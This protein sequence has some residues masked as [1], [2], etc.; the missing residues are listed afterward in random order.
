MLIT[1][2][3][4][5]LNKSMAY[6]SV[7]EGWKRKKKR[8]QTGLKKASDYPRGED[9]LGHLET[10]STRL[11]RA[12]RQLGGLSGLLGEADTLT[13][14]ENEAL[15]NI[16]NLNDQ[17]EQGLQHEMG[18]QV[19]KNKYDALCTVINNLKANPTFYQ[20]LCM[21]GAESK[22]KNQKQALK[23]ILSDMVDA[24]RYRD[25]SATEQNIRESVKR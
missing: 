24:R 4:E 2:L 16:P 22:K 14:D 9:P 21:L 25:A 11:C 17:I 7:N 15:K 5:K 6:T 23:G 1:E 20:S 13:A 8:D 12:D 10:T 19:E 18:N 3:R